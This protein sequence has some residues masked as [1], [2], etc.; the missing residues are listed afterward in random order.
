MTAP[1]PSNLPPVGGGYRPEYGSEE[2]K[3]LLEKLAELKGDGIKI[4]S[5]Q[6]EF[7]EVEGED[8]LINIVETGPGKYKLHID[9]TIERERQKPVS[10]FEEIEVELKEPPTNQKLLRWMILIAATTYRN[11]M[12]AASKKT[13]DHQYV[14][15]EKVGTIRESH[16]MRVDMPSVS[17]MS[18]GNFKAKVVDPNKSADN[19]NLANIRL[20]LSSRAEQ[21][22]V[23]QEAPSPIEP[24]G[25]HAVHLDHIKDTID[26]TVREF[27]REIK[28]LREQVKQ[29]TEEIVLSHHDIKEI[30]MKEKGKSKHAKEHTKQLWLQDKKK[31]FKKQSHHLLNGMDAD[32]EKL[33]TL[34]P[35]SD[36]YLKIEKN[37]RSYTQHLEDNVSK[38]K[39][40]LA[41]H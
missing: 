10:H 33:K 29:K 38:L 24:E 1:I 26:E 13:D 28:L 34:E 18:K 12:I 39:A 9:W 8:N 22:T 41:D 3:N 31:E 4:L 16:L 20:I 19:P 15:Q 17:E 25:V 5:V 11:T 30:E 40:F 21:P 2:P 7:Q 6:G 36:N 35:N 32:I 37:I 27:S 14:G 23:A